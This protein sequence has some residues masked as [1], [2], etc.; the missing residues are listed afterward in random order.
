MIMLKKIYFEHYKAFAGAEEIELRPITLIVGK[1]SSGKSS[2][3]KLL[4]MLSKMVSGTIRY[5]LLLN[6]DGIMNATEYEDLFFKRENT[7]LKLAVEYDNDV[8][9]S[10][11]YFIQ[12]GV[13][14]YNQSA[15]CC[16]I[17]GIQRCEGLQL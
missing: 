12:D 11:N 16:R 4:P 13:K 10:G 2:V 15:G 8:V 1:N 5:P 9:L 3:L 17:L 7:G 14:L 6:N